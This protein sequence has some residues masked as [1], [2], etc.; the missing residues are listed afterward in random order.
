MTKK[1]YRDAQGYLRFV[2]SGKLVHRWKAERKIGRKLQLG[3]IVHHENKIK[4][5]NRY[6][7]LRIF[8]SRKAHQAYHIKRAWTRGRRSKTLKR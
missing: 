3:E 8:N 6:S 7:N 4:I 2:D 5:D 1:T